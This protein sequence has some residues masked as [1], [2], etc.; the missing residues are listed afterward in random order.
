MQMMQMQMH[1]QQMTQQQAAAAAQPPAAQPPA[2]QPPAAQPST[3]PFVKAS[4]VLVSASKDGELVRAEGQRTSVPIKVQLNDAQEPTGVYSTATSVRQKAA[5]SFP[6]AGSG[7][8][9]KLFVGELVDEKISEVAIVSG[10]NDA[11]ADSSWRELFSCKKLDGSTPVIFVQPCLVGHQSRDV[12]RKR[13]ASMA[14]TTD[15]PELKAAVATLAVARPKKHGKG[16]DGASIRSGTVA[17]L[18]ED[19]RLVRLQ[20]R[21]QALVDKAQTAKYMDP[22]T[23]ESC[24][25]LT[26]GK[27]QA[28]VVSNGKVVTAGFYPEI[29]VQDIDASFLDSDGRLKDEVLYFVCR[30]PGCI[31]K[32]QAG[33]FVSKP[34]GRAAAAGKKMAAPCSWYRAEVRMESQ[35]AH[36][37][38]TTR[39]GGIV[40]RT[41]S[42]MTKDHM[43]KEHGGGFDKIEGNKAAAI[44][45]VFSLGAA[46]LQTPQAQAELQAAA[47]AAAQSAAPQQPPALTPADPPG[48]PPVVLRY[49]FDA[50]AD[51]KERDAAAVRMEDI[52][53]KK[54]APGSMVS[55]RV[56]DLLRRYELQCALNMGVPSEQILLM[57]PFDFQLI[58]RRMVNFQKTTG[59]V[60]DS[61]QR[62]GSLFATFQLLDVLQQKVGLK[63]PH[64]SRIFPS[65]LQ[66]VSIPI[67]SEVHDSE[68][69]WLPRFDVAFSF[70]SYPSLNTKQVALAHMF[71]QHVACSAVELLKPAVPHQPK[72]GSN[73]NVCAFSATL[74]LKLALNLLKQHGP[75]PAFVQALRELSV[76]ESEYHEYR[77]RAK[78]DINSLLNEYGRRQQEARIEQRERERKRANAAEPGTSSA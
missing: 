58:E 9:W 32:A 3:A 57:P 2:A 68:F 17:Q 5:A 35:S 22:C 61:S 48:P 15:G 11:D 23:G 27:W 65:A 24:L 4:I 13:A 1:M 45:R 56:F 69:I 55:S 18:S 16:M 76:K 30:S 37:K 40:L 66:L 7:C 49:P 29:C 52:S 44:S 74:F 8:S 71:V 50:P 62:E 41:L 64:S 33:A 67:L 42:T 10:E 21:V 14:V 59:I 70:D 12:D 26:N 43:D 77:M 6:D 38:S 36:H 75:T 19:S 54:L 47:A 46:L 78:K 39:D 51:A 28:P 72:E 60:I 73:E 31:H 20:E 34:T 53:T 25:I 63:S